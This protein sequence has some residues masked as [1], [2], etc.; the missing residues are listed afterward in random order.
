MAKFFKF[1]LLSL[2]STILCANPTFE[3]AL[4]FDDAPRPDT[5]YFTG[6]E[7]TNKIVQVL[8]EKDVRQVAFFCNTFAFTKDD[9]ERIKKYSRA[10][11][12][13][14]NHTAHHIDYQKSTFDHFTGDILEA[15][16]TLAT[17]PTYKKWFRF[18][19]LRQGFLE[20]SRNQI[21]RFLEKSSYQHGYVTVETYDWELDR[22]F[23]QD[24]AKG[25]KVNL[26]ELRRIYLQILWEG[27]EFYND[28]SMKVLKRIPKQVILLHEN[29]INALFLGD[30]VDIIRSKQ[31]RMITIEEA[32]KDPIAATE[33]DL[34][35][36]SQ[37]RLR[38]IAKHDN[39]SG[40]TVSKWE[41]EDEIAKLYQSMTTTK[42]E[43]K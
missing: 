28:L 19:Y 12:I 21:H 22:L 36:F 14:A 15:E 10:G 4:T 23:Q 29:D 5:A 27:I 11:H 3:I 41:D 9:S 6:A 40:S 16:R 26:D 34:L 24:V 33:Y 42:D 39:Y 30:L 38:S 1:I 13:I 43:L 17:F 7:R 18:P 2:Y 8:K 35:P 37:R 32:Y 31:G 25:K 20:S